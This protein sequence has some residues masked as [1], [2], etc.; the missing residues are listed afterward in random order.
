MPP[1]DDIEK[2]VIPLINA[3]AQG[4][5]GNTFPVNKQYFNGWTIIHFACVLGF[6]AV[7]NLLPSI[8]SFV[9]FSPTCFNN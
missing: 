1:L 6:T 3:I 8:I 2:L 5:L 9:F 4:Q 7:I